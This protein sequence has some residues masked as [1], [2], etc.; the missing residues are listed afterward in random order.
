MGNIEIRPYRDSDFPSVAQMTNQ[1]QS[2]FVSL[3]SHAEK[4]L[5]A[6][7]EDTESYVR[8]ALKDVC[9]MN[10]AVFVAAEK[11]KIVGFIQGVIVRHDNDVMH[12]LTHHPET[13]GWIGLFF[14]DPDQ[15]GKGVGKAL[16][17]K[18]QE[19]FASKNCQ[20]IRLKV[21]S[22]NELAMNVYAEYGFTPRDLE[23]VMHIPQ[24]LKIN[25]SDTITVRDNLGLKR[26]ADSSM[27]FLS[28]SIVGRFSSNRPNLSTDGVHKERIVDREK[29]YYEE[30]VVDAKTG[31]VIHDVEE[32]LTEH[33]K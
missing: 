28:H 26:F 30:K 11:R 27:K 33:R 31:R 9:E 5:F 18:M 15:R 12:S 23:M 24:S 19:Y 13:E 16:L 17:N 2:Y 22:N 20:S 32:K 10:G 25:V 3:D 21:A 29:D 8:Q 4:K 7:N 1:L 6:K 14:T